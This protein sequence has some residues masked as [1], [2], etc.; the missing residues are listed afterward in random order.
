M[1]KFFN[2]FKE[3]AMKGNVIDLA[4]GIVIGTAF[5]KIVSSL[6]ADI[7]MPIVGALTAGID[8]KDLTATI[9]AL[10]WNSEAVALPYGLFL[11]NLFNFA[12]VALAIFLLVKAINTAKERMAKKAVKEQEKQVEETKLSTDQ[13][14]LTEIRDLL[15]KTK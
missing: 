12:I 10:P 6:V 11:Q 14:L 2:E 8:F 3:F 4:V 7:I 13:E 1:W 15:K 9:P 5:G